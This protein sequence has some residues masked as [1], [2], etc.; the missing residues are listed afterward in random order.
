[1]QHDSEKLLNVT[2]YTTNYKRAFI[3]YDLR[4]NAV[5]FKNF[6]NYFLNDIS[7]SAVAEYE[8]PRRVMRKVS[9]YNFELKTH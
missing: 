5:F 1:M 3:V 6:E 7:E 2:D 8:L 9:C 4:R